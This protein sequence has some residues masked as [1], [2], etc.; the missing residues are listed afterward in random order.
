MPDTLHYRC[1]TDIAS[2]ISSLNLTAASPPGN[3]GAN[4]ITD[5]LP[6]DTVQFPAIFVTVEGMT[7]EEGEGNFEQIEVTY[8]VL[9]QI[10]DR[11]I[12][13]R[14]VTLEQY[15]DWRREIANEFRNMTTL[16]SVPECVD[17]QV[18]MNPVIDPQ[19]DK[20]SYVVSGM[21]IRCRTFEARDK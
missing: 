12:D 5:A 11:H 13:E 18:A 15:Q 14:G 16:A 7:E 10:A 21:V 2:V 6:D 1:M 20:Y 4:V 3:I 9:V 17:I 8:P 19:L